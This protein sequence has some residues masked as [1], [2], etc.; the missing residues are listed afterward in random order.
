MWVEELEN[1]KYRA[2]ER[3][4]DYLTG[5]QKKVSI[6]I[7]KNTAKSR[8]D[9]QRTLDARIAEKCKSAE[10]HE[11]TLKELVEEYRK[12]QKGE[13]K[14]STYGRNYYICNTLMRILGENVI[15]GHMTS[16]YV[17]NKFTITSFYLIMKLRFWIRSNRF[18]M[19]LIERKF[20]ISFWSPR[21]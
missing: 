12:G 17:K 13:I 8:K 3:Y 1:G 15:V 6:T 16:R 7:E 18:R 19:F 21:N 10:N 5:K 4:T 9:A 2:V 11:Y 20:K 14:E